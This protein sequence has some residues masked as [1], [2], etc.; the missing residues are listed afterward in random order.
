MTGIIGGIVKPLIGIKD[1]TPL[2]TPQS[3]AAPT[4]DQSQVDR[5]NADLIRRRKGAAATVTGAAD[6]GSTAGSV[7]AK[8]LLGQ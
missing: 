7:A 5:A 4:V 2:P 8:T 1:P 3:V 6:V